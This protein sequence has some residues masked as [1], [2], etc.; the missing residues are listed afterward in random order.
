MTGLSP[1]AQELQA[2]LLRRYLD[3]IPE[4]K[5][6][7]ERAWEAVQNDA[8]SADALAR[9]KTP[10]HRLAGSAGSYGL[11]ELGQ[12]ARALDVRLK[13]LNPTPEQRDEIQGQF[14]VLLGALAE[15]QEKT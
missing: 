9:F 1:R 15:A 7:L 5:A 13:S 4:K 14:G 3:S 12:A 2:R 10:V 8:W 11:D 6:E